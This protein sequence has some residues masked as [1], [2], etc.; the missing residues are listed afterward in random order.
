MVIE[1]GDGLA[2][3]LVTPF[4]CVILWSFDDTAICAQTGA[5]TRLKATQTPVMVV[6]RMAFLLAG[7]LE[8]SF[9]MRKA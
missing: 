7:S 8:R 6:F 2:T 4:S 9:G 3:F 1:S 5:E